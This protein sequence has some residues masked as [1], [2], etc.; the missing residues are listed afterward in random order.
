LSVYFV[1]VTQAGNEEF[2]GKADKGDFKAFTNLPEGSEV[3]RSATISLDTSH[4]SS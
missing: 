2:H 1:A 3:L 4:I